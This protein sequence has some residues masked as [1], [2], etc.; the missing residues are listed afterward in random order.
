MG[1]FSFNL[2]LLFSELFIFYFFLFLHFPCG[3]SELSDAFTSEEIHI[4]PRCY[5]PKSHDGVNFACCVSYQFF[6]FF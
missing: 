3:I 2:L 6:F 4:Q 1:T 5:N